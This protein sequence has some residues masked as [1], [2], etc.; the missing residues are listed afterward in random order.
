MLGRESARRRSGLTLLEVLV[1]LAIL[2][3]GSAAWV[4][5]VAQGMHAARM[6]D[7]RDAQIQHAAL[8]L[9]RMSTWSRTQLAAHVGRT[10]APGFLV[11]VGE[12]TPSLYDVVIADT[13]RG[14]VLLHTSFYV[15]ESSVAR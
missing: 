13:V 14:A 4:G 7:S 1:A 6:S 10:A 9:A 15:R 12:V 3:L 8:Q 2:G 11:I 5:L